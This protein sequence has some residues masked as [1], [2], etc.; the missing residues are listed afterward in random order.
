MLCHPGQP[1]DGGAPESQGLGRLSRD[2]RYEKRAAELDGYCSLPAR[3]PGLAIEVEE[4]PP[5]IC[6][7]RERPV[8]RS[9]AG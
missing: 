9:G 1:K 5:H 2:C 6:L 4:A 7:Q 3:A 8:S